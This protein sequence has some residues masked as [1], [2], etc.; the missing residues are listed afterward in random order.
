MGFN[1]HRA[2]PPSM[3]SPDRSGSGRRRQAEQRL[4]PEDGDAGNPERSGV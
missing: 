1:F 2:V 3:I 4:G